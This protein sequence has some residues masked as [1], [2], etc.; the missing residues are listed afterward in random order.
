MKDLT[1]EIGIYAKEKELEKMKNSYAKA[2]RVRD[3]LEY[4]TEHADEL[5]ILINN[6]NAL[7]D[8]GVKLHKGTYLDSQDSYREGNF[9]ANGFR[10]TLGFVFSDAPH[11]ASRRVIGM[12]TIGGGA[13]GN[14]SVVYLQKY[15]EAIYDTDKYYHFTKSFQMLHPLEEL[16]E[17]TLGNYEYE[18]SRFANS[19]DDFTEHFEAYINEVI[20]K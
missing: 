17:R 8:A 7:L 10:H 6:A 16:N 18:A 12:A 4:I 11:M 15:H 5:D 13:N 1:M 3:S 14:V 19:I 20:S 2:K 9:E